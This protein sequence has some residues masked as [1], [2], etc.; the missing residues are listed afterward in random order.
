MAAKDC[1]NTR[2]SGLTE[3]T[4]DNVASLKPAWTFSTGVLR[5]HEGAPL[6]VGDTMYIVTPYPNNLYALDLTKPGAPVKWTYRPKPLAASQGVACCDTVNR[7]AAYADGKIFYNTLD[8]HTVGIDA[9]SG[10]EIW[11]T[12]IGDIALGETLT[13]APLVVK[14]KVIVGNS[15]GEMGIRGR[16]TA[17]DVATGAIAWRAFHTGSD[18]DVLIGPNFKPF[19]ASDRG[20]DL[21][22]SSWP[23]G[24]WK[25][26]GAPAWGWISYDPDLDLIFY[27]TG[28]PAPWNPELRPG[29]NKW[30]CTVFARRPDTGEAVWAYQYNPHD[31]YDHDS[32][33]EHLVLDLPF[34]GQT[35]RLLVHPERNGHMYVFDRASGEILSAEPFAF[36]NTSTGV[37]L[38][39]GRPMMVTEKTPITGKVVRNICPAAPG[40]KDWQPVSYSPQTGLLYVPHQNLCHDI[41]ALDVGYIAGTPYVG[42][43]V[44]MYAGPGGHRG[45]L[46]AW[47]IVSAKQVWMIKENF[48]VWSGTVATA[49]DVVFYGTMEGWFKAVHAKSGAPLWQFKTGS[50]IVGQPITYRGPDGK[51]YVAVFSGVGG[52]AGA[53]VAGNLDARDPTAA[54]GFVNAMSDLP[55]HSTKGGTLH[56]FSLP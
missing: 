3:I 31:L 35:R 29:D 28:N 26:G 8:N 48:P 27:G 32:V 37:D 9:T 17:L 4:A 56:V 23:A 33:N 54:L 24:M 46:Q 36:T 41:E 22:V 43:N 34:K 18:A 55:Q 53:I 40:A 21:G 52:W 12:R 44:K 11:K 10:Q 49:G 30:S 38:K 16:V 7:G 51:Q 5:G 6:V 25:T 14:G 47:D 20:A 42:A 39:T 13:M 15:G 19:Y 45:Q 50:G 1:A 2:F